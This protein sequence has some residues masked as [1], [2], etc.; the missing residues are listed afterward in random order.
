MPSRT[1]GRQEAVNLARTEL[2]KKPVYL[3]TETTGMDDRA[4]IVEICIVDSDA[5][6][7][8][9]QLVK[10]K[11]AIPPDTVKIHGI[12]NDMVKDAPAWSEVWPEVA[13]VL[14]NRRVAIYNADFDLRMIQQSHSW[15]GIPWDF[16]E[17][18]LFCLMKLYARFNGEWNAKYGNYRW[19][20][21]EEAAARCRLQ[22]QNSHRAKADALL[23][24]EL[25][26]Y[27]AGQQ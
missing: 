6:I 9:E 22:G 25:L 2:S 19:Y 27:I 8:L 24:R 26:V 21:L 1:Q 13:R 16:D 23:A 14:A 11:D 7:L 12:T 3:D 20:R 4:Q 15:H 5:N 17:D 18:S 10:P